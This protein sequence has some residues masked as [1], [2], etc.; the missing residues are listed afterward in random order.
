[1]EITQGMIDAVYI[2][3]RAIAFLEEL[4]LLSEFKTL[5]A[6]HPRDIITLDKLIYTNKKMGVKANE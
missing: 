3:G 2:A 6:N 4:G 5:I 1:M